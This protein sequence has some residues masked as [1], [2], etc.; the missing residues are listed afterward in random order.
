[1]ECQN[2]PILKQA[3]KL[4]NQIK[5]EETKIREIEQKT[6]SQKLTTEEKYQIFTMLEKT[7][8]PT[9]SQAQ[10]DLYLKLNRIWLDVVDYRAILRNLYLM[11]KDLKVAKL[12]W[13]SLM[14][15]YT[16]IFA[17]CFVCMAVLYIH[18]LMPL[19]FK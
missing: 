2:S 4:E 11:K 12:N 18:V 6:N 14:P 19:F 15:E 7:L 8:S 16:Y 10:K 13:R 9:S 17:S 1:M 5:I 3:I